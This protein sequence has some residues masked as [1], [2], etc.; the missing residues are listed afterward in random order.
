MFCP[1]AMMG[2][3]KLYVPLARAKTVGKA[4]HQLSS[5]VTFSIEPVEAVSL[6]YIVTARDWL[7]ARAPRS[8]ER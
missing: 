3:V 5:T 8:N 6:T 4:C 7:V 2:I 1:A